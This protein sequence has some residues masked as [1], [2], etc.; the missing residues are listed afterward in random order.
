MDVQ[1]GSQAS[2]L[3][4]SRYTHSRGEGEPPDLEPPP[5][6]LEAPTLPSAHDI[7]EVDFASLHSSRPHND[8]E[9]MLCQHVLGLPPPWLEIQGGTMP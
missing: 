1:R 7:R 6:N 5:Q 3:W 2:S 9:H 8:D 4:Y